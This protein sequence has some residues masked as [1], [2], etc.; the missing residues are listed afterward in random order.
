MQVKKWGRK[1][2]KKTN[3]NKE[4][5]K[6]S[7]N[8][9][10]SYLLNPSGLRWTYKSNPIPGISVKGT[11]QASIQPGIQGASNTA[12]RTKKNMHAAEHRQA[13][14]KSFES[15]IKRKLKSEYTKDM[16]FIFCSEIPNK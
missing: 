5:T 11:L 9:S 6:T 1:Y 10:Y 15:K 14:F 16:Q 3:I 4:Q 13:I 7:T 8:Q 12:L 2:F